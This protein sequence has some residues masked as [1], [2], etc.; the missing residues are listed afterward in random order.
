V[1]GVG[2]PVVAQVA[3]VCPAG[4]PECARV[5]QSAVDARARAALAVSGGAPLPGSASTLGRRTATSRHASL[6]LR[7]TAVGADAFAPGAGAGDPPG[8][9]TLIALSVDGALALFDGFVAAPTVG[10]VLSIDALASAGWLGAGGPIDARGAFVWGAGLRVGVLRESFTLPGL[11]VSA[12]YRDIARLTAGDGAAPPRW[13]VDA[14]A[15]SLRATVGKRIAALDAIV[16][17]GWDRAGGS[18][19]AGYTNSLS[20]TEGAGVRDL[21][22]SRWSA[23]AGAGWTFLVFQLAGELGW[24]EGGA[25]HAEEAFRLAGSDGAWFGTLSFRF[26]Y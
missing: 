26:T 8:S 15:L 1:S 14:D 11:T 3:D 17:G 12:M 19:A 18:A 10:G 23:F 16:G 24:V 21:H 7:L 2:S 20:Q 6:A 13:D 4:E 9:G 25:G 5:V 22:D